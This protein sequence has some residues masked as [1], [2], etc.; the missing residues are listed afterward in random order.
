MNL[1]DVALAY[2][3]KDPLEKENQRS[4]RQIVRNKSHNLLHCSLLQPVVVLHTDAFL[5]L[6]DWHLIAL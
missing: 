6:H 5:R 1:A 3:K 2:E 4:V